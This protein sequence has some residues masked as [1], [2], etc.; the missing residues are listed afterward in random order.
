MTQVD[1]LGRSPLHYAALENDSQAALKLLHGGADPKAT[2]RHGFTPLHF[3][4]QEWSVDVAKPLLE[5]GAPVD[6]INVF[7][8]T[9]LFVAVFNSRG[10]GEMIELLRSCGA[11]P[12]HEN[13]AGQ[14]P[15]DLARLIAN[16]DVARFFDDLSHHDRSD[17]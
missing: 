17:P 11:N 6:A 15:L 7:G 8:N 16:Y 4:P 12:L 1:H 9:P 14:S 2:D 10:R 5:N 3:A 13:D